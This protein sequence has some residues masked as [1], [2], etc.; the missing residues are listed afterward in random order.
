MKWIE[1]Y[2]VNVFVKQFMTPPPP[3]WYARGPR[4]LIYIIIYHQKL[5][6]IHHKIYFMIYTHLIVLKW[7]LRWIPPPKYI[8]FCSSFCEKSFIN[9]LTEYIKIKITCVYKLV[10]TLPVE[11][12]GWDDGFDLNLVQ[13]KRTFLFQ[14]LM[15]TSFKEEEEICKRS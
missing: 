15:K 3:I 6:A 11:L 8:L 4:N 7:H 1:C 10:K 13:I 9:A 14:N 5:R 12:N 2:I